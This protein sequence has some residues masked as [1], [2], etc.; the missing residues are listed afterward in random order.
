MATLLHRAEMLNNHT[1]DSNH[2][3]M[4]TM[5]QN[6][7]TRYMDATTMT[8]RADDYYFDVT[9]TMDYATL[10]IWE[11][12]IRRAEARW[13]TDLTA[14]NIYA[15]RLPDALMDQYQPTPWAASI[16]APA[17]ASAL[18]ALQS[19]TIKLN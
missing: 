7:W 16:S 17:S 19:R 13:L 15:A 6:L 5:T 2:K 4:L 9:C 1:C 3:K 14:M 18:A 10:T 12:G 8:S 11:D